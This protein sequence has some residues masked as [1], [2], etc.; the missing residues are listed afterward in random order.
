MPQVHQPDT[1][2][3]TDPKGDPKPQT[4][5]A[6]AVIPPEFAQYTV[7][8]GDTFA[9]IARHYYGSSA[10]S[11]VIIAANPLMSPDH[12]TIGRVIKIPKDPNNIQGR[13]VAP[14]TTPRADAGHNA[15]P[16][17]RSARGAKP[18]AS[19][20]TSCSRG[21]PCR[22]SRPRCTGTSASPRLFTTPIETSCPTSTPSRSGRS[23]GSLR[24][25]S[26]RPLRKDC[27]PMPDRG[28]YIVTG[29]AG[30]IGS[31][32]VA[33][34][35]KQDP[36]CEV[37]VVDDLRSGSFANIVGAMARAG[38][39]P[40]SGRFLATR[41]EDLDATGLVAT[42]GLRAIFH[43]AAITDTT[44]TNEAEMIRVNSQGFEPLLMACVQAGMPL[45]YASSAATYG[46]PPQTAQRRPFPVS[47]AGSP[48]NVYGFSKWLM[49]CSHG[50]IGGRSALGTPHVVGLR[51]F[52]VFGPG[53]GRKGKMA[54]MVYQLATAML[55]G[56]RPRLFVDGSQARDQVYVDDAVACT[57]AGLG[58]GTTMRPKPGVYN[59]GSGVAIGFKQ[60]IAA[61]REELAISEATLPTEYFEMPVEVREF[62]QDFTQADLGATASGLGWKPAWSPIDA[63][64]T[65]AKCLKTKRGC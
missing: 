20:S 39:P 49:E 18:P 50:R 19:G 37:I 13:P 29:G 34:L 41:L 63:I 64:R 24:D 38:L 28:C 2:P 58:I 30:F 4:D 62:Y 8:E 31:N 60:I 42:R 55:A 65:Y 6:I 43:L 45:V 56:K 25:R 27:P 33:A 51:Y 47:A 17:A 53:E 36:A 61:L 22:R 46:T 26:G 7:K 44:V 10:L 1:K 40:Y 16:C 48:S 23:S 11:S 5:P 54:S 57:M 32:L 9:S 14:G 59:V 12:L 15:G 21:T 3:G 35:T 52:N